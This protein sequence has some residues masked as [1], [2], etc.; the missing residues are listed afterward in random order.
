MGPLPSPSTHMPE[1][2]AVYDD[3]K[4]IG[5]D[6]P[7]LG[8]LEFL[9][10]EK[11]EL[12]EGKVCVVVFL[13]TYSKDNF[14]NMTELSELSKQYP[15]VAFTGVLVDP[16]GTREDPKSKATV[17]NFLN[18][19]KDDTIKRDPTAEP[20]HI[21]FPVAYDPTKEYK[22]KWQ[23]DCKQAA[24]DIPTAFIVGK[25]GKILWREK[26][27]L[28]AC[29]EEQVRC[30]CCIPGAARACGRGQADGVAGQQAE[31]RGRGRGGGGRGRFRHGV[32]DFLNTN[33]L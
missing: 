30:W 22:N 1:N 9:Q 8:D 17:T 21:A 6:A 18:Y 28:L 5:V 25:D 23:E 13:T 4:A 29:Q 24:I 33:E 15:N 14:P 27:G 3:D 20:P 2:F 16:L 12:G 19:H 7:K 10:G 31:G 26:F 11:V 32:L